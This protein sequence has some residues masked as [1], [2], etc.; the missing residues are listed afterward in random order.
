[1]DDAHSCKE[2]GNA[3][4]SAGDYVNA[5]KWYSK[6]ISLAPKDSA[7]FS[8]RSFCFLKLGL[9]NRAL[10][11]ADEAIRWRPN[12]AKAH[13]RRAAALTSAGLHEKALM[14]YSAGATCDPSDAH[15]QSQCNDARGR[16][17]QA[18]KMEKIQCGSAV[19][20]VA[21]ILGLMTLG[22][23][24]TSGASS[25]VLA[26]LCGG[27]LGALGGAGFVLFRRQ[28]RESSMLEPLQ[29]NHDFAVM[30]M[31]GDTGR[32]DELR[33]APPPREDDR[34][35]LPGAFRDSSQDVSAAVGAHG[36]SG[37]GEKKEKGG[38]RRSTAN[39][40]AAAMRAKKEGRL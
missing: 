25:L 15:L 23:G 8:N 36:A 34:D 22:D 10:M 2:H 16:A 1:M 14:S 11:D 31:A 20:T 32:A 40:R 7:L 4:M 33:A 12:W 38:A 24:A 19:I 18:R 27:L 28:Q 3:M 35:G 29:S 30:Q 5:L 6:A 26:L 17:A 37:G 21:V 13:F 9:N 39:G